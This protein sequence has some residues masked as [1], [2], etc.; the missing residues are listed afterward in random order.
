MNQA[1]DRASQLISEVPITGED[2]NIVTEHGTTV[3]NAGSI[4]IN[5]EMIMILDPKKFAELT[6]LASNFEVYRKTDD[7]IQFDMMFYD[8]K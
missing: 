2:I 1:Y 8:E 5:G 7:T 6:S 3:S 4:S